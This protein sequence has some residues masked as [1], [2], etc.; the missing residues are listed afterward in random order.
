MVPLRR[1]VGMESSGALTGCLALFVLLSSH[2][3]LFHAR[4][5]EATVDMHL[6]AIDRS[7]RGQGKRIRAVERP[8]VVLMENLIDIKFL[9]MP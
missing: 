1:S 8:I 3:L 2:G 4:T 9:P 5:D 6:T 7:A